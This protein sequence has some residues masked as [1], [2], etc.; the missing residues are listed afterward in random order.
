MHGFQ[1][2]VNLPRA[3]K[4][5]Q[6]R[7]QEIPAANIPSAHS[8]DGK[9]R[10]KVIA[11]EALG[12]RAVIDTH[13]PIIYQHWTLQPGAQVTAP[14]AGDLMGIVYVFEGAATIAG[15]RLQ[16]G[17]LAVLSAGDAVELAAADVSG[18]LLLLAGRPLREPIAR[19]GPFVMNTR[20]ELEHAF[21]D[22]ESGMLGEITRTARRS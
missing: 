14:L 17:Q 18:Q 19:Y 4:L 13:T 16:S 12:A 2:W 5:T 20:Q 1:I 9:A 11:G 7:Y 22:Y 6:P 3:L 21:A 15:R 8:A 10:V